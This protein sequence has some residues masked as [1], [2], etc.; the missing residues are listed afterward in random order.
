MAAQY[1][2]SPYADDEISLVDLWRVLA[3]RR[4]WILGT[5]LVVMVLGG[6]WLLF[7]TPTH[8]ARASV[9]IGT[10]AKTVAEKAQPSIVISSKAKRGQGEIPSQ[11]PVEPLENPGAVADRI[12]YTQT[13]GPSVLHS[14]EQEKRVI[15]LTARSPTP[16]G[17]TELLREIVDRLQSRHGEY[18]K[19]FRSE[20]QE[21]ISRI[22]QR[23]SFIGEQQGR[24]EAKLGELD[25]NTSAAIGA[26]LTLEQRL[27][28]QLPRLEERQAELQG[29]LSQ[30]LTQP[31]EVI[32]EP[33]ASSSPVEPKT[34]LV[35]A[36]A[37]VLGLML[38]V[39]V[40]FF[41]EFLARVSE[42]GE[43][44]G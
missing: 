37:A 24:F 42:A 38:G 7:Q 27:F 31:T 21:R 20:L 8:E 44:E 33:T 1:Q 2:D 41:R 28:N 14:V 11:P 17:A 43:E 36:L 34:R 25:S 29:Q 5:F 12:R 15:T 39:F 35:L 40:A 9:E 3:R 16:E 19:A 32:S 22:S 23:I 4:F 13:A 10:V 6:I 30:R 18:I 26:L